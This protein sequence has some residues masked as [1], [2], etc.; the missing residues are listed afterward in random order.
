MDS[1][2]ERRAAR[3]RELWERARQLL[4]GGVS[5][6]VR[7]F[8][9]VG[10]T[11]RFIDRAKGPYVTDVDGIRYVDYVM[12]WGPLI[13]GHAHP[14]VVQAVQRQAE[15]GT[16][17]GAPT[18]VELALAEAITAAM[19]SMERVRFVN[20]GTEAAMSALRLARAFTGR[21]K[22]VK[23][24]G[25]YHGHADSL[26]V[27]AGSG[28]LTLGLPGSPGVT[29]GAAAD[30]WVL[31]YN[32]VAAVEELFARHG[33][34]IAAVI[35]EPIAGNMGV[36]PP[37]PGFLP[38]LRRL[39]REAGALLIFD[40]VITGF[41]VGLGGAQGLL[42]I[43]PDLTCL[44]KIIGGGL[45]VGAY[46]GRADIMER[47]APAGPVYQA[48]T[49]S[50]NPLAMAAGLATLEVVSQPGTYERL[51]RQAARL[52]EG[53]LAEARAQDVPYC[54]QR[55]GSMW[56][57][58]FHPGPLRNLEEVRRSDTAFYARYFHGML[59][60][61]VYLPPSAF[62]AAFVSLAHTDQD[63]EFT[64]EAHAR[65]LRRARQ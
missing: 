59:R 54:V 34:E 48:G 14:A 3:S 36:V 61:G 31:P 55:V 11:P 4:P 29:A 2:E 16:A 64:V 17:Y 50:G 28:V 33:E 24:A 45:P 37:D 10:G 65:A 13:L 46:G 39:T 8:A 26:L 1:G 15:Q 41:R 21:D 9:A 38:A 62:E 35:V 6:P 58:F 53:L 18:E 42:G 40:E 30:T 49:L 12:A 23:F 7:A 60:E 19:P 44:G 43:V 25:C 51:E 47:V 32:D 57:G 5:S 22:I 63:I 52:A 20:S 56:T 27:E